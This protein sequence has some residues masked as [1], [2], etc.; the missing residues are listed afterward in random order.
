MNI[1]DGIN[2]PDDIKKLNVHELRTLASEIRSFLIENISNTGGHLA[3]NLGIVELTLALHKIFTTPEDR[4]VWDVGHQSYVHKI[5]TGR[6]TR[7]ETLRKYDGLS[8]FPKISESRHDCFGTGHSSTAVSA[9]L[10][11]ARAR[12][13]NKDDYQVIAVVGDGALTGG[14]TYEAL[15][16]AGHS[17]TKLIVILN[18]NGM[19]IAK[20]VGGISKY[21]SRIRTQPIY[22]KVKKDLDI[23]LGNIPY[24]GKKASI[25]LNRAKGSIKFLII[26]G[27]IFEELGFEYLGPI[28]GHDINELLKVLSRARYMKGPVLIHICTKKGKGYPHAEAKPDEFHGIS[29]FQIE[30]GDLKTNNVPSLSDEFGMHLVELGR[31]DGT[32]T[33]ITATMSH[34]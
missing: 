30:T 18:D 32:K 3:S 25:L 27:M 20:N 22:Y 11:I 19:S 2:S 15:N 21:L 34:S 7:F 6:K 28:D 29:P 12:D 8:G 24:I 1:I 5:I 13:L 17:K 4:I 23:F 10:G 9:A 33:A 26:P 14:L 16:D 31:K